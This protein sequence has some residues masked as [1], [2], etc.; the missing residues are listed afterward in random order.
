M[1]STQITKKSL[2]IRFLSKVKLIIENNPVLWYSIFAVIGCLLL[3]LGIFKDYAFRDAHEYIWTANNSPVFKNEFVEGGRFLL[4]LICQFVYGNLSDSITDL[5]WI[6]LFSLITSVIFSTQIFSFLIKQKLKIYESAVFSFLILTIPSFTVYIGWTAT[7]EIPFILC[8]TFF[9]GVI[10][11]KAID[12]KENI[13]L[14]Y[15][16]A[17]LIVSICLCIYQPAVT[18]FLLPFVFSIILNKKIFLNKIIVLLIFLGIAF[19]IY[20]FIFKLSLIWYNL[21]PSKRSEIEFL[22]LPVNIIIFYLKEM[23]ML[24]YGN[25]ILILPKLFFTFGVFSFFG[26][27]FLIYQKRKIIPQFFLFVSFLILIF[28]LSYAPNL[29]SSTSYICSRTIAPAAI[30]V[31]FYQFLFFRKLCLKNKIFKL[32]TLILVLTS[33]IF[34]SINQ[35]IYIAKIQNKEYNSIKKAFN[36]IALDNR[37][38]I[39]IIKPKEDF[40]QEFKFYKHIYADEF[41]Q[42][43]SSRIWVP[44]P[45]FKQILKERLDSLGLKKN[46]FFPNDIKVLDAKDAYKNENAIIINLID[47]LKDEFRK[48]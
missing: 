48:N 36:N 47:I 46:Y 18:A 15:S 1:V 17:L 25:G 10:L 32:P 23:R 42:V 13:I 41:V 7:H 5:K 4:G 14:N 12:K 2:I 8:L 11:Q 20:Y 30:I 6:R 40:L 31:L 29:L 43:S 26:F 21:E 16:I 35:N 33:I 37:K 9:A 3:N 34:S 19:I 45:M 22:K 24:F 44:E 38:K 28:P 39:I 27:L